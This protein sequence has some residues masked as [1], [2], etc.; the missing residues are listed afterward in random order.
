MK[1]L[2]GRVAAGAFVWACCS[3]P[4]MAVSLE[5]LSINGFLDL[6]YE[7]ADGPGHTTTPVADEAG[8]FDQYHFNLL[9]EFPV[10][11]IVVAK[12]HIEYEHGPSLENQQGDITIE[13]AY[14][15]YLFNNVV[16][17]RGGLANTPFGLYNEIHDATPTYLSVRVPWEI[18]K[19][20]AVGGHA[21][22]PKFS[23]GVFILGRNALPAGVTLNYTAYLVN[24]ENDTAKMTRKTKRRKTRTPRNPSGDK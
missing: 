16:R 14:I 20:Q 5:K 19:T 17:L 12:G 23:T 21:M 18:Y 10:S 13:W 6:E 24:G 11:D 4:A 1:R 3:S 2:I 7:K 9:M 15:E 22:F 8:S